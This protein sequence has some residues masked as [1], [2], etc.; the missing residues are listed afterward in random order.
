[1]RNSV[2]FKNPVNGALFK[3]ARRAAA[4][5]LLDAIGMGVKPLKLRLKVTNRCSAK[6]FMCNVWKM[7][8]NWAPSLPHELTVEQYQRLFDANR[9]YLSNIKRIC[10]TGGEPTMRRDLVEIARIVSTAVPKAGMSLNTNG[11]STRRVLDSVR[12]I[13]EFRKK[14]T[15]MISLDGIG[16]AHDRTRGVRNVFPK[17]VETIDGLLEMKRTEGAG[18]KVEINHVMTER[19]GDQAPLVFA[20][21]QERGIYFNPIYVIHGELYDND[22]V[23]LNYTPELRA[24]LLGFIRELMQKDDNLQLREAADM[25]EG[26]E[27]DYDCWAGRTMFVL[28]DDG[29]LYPNGGCPKDFLLGNIKDFDFDLKKLLASPRARAVVKKAKSCRLCRLSC[30]TMTTLRYPEALVGWLRTRRSGASISDD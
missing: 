13:L 8:D 9:S 11:F 4:Y 23:E 28:E 17:V 29:Q 30:E 18:L 3:A 19:N 1:M 6:C 7:Q 10:L 25:L 24:K 26:R 22:G 14:L 20:F 15:V 16:E 2:A 5:H 12:A 27:R 21:C